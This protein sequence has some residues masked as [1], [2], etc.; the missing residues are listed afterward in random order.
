MRGYMYEST[1]DCGRKRERN[2]VKDC[3]L[4]PVCGDLR[5]SMPRP[6]T[7]SSSI[8]ASREASRNEPLV[9]EKEPLAEDRP[10]TESSAAGGPGFGA[11]APSL[12]EEGWGLGRGVGSPSASARRVVRTSGSAARF[13]P[14]RERPPRCGYRCGYRC[15]Y[16]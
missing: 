11:A 12:G 1:S 6:S 14:R 8:A 15:C 9:L 10:E 3:G 16:R 4:S 7:S 2:A 5:P 13:L